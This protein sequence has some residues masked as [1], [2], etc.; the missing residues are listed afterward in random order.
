MPVPRPPTSN[1]PAAPKAR[2]GPTLEAVVL[3][4]GLSSRMGRDKSRLVLAGRTLAS[5]SAD[6]ARA[7]D[8]PVRTLR[9]DA[10]PRCGPLG[11]IA[12]ALS[13][14]RA[15]VLVFLSCDM[16][17]LGERVLRRLIAAM[18]PRRAAAFVECDGRIGFPFALRKDARPAV[19]ALR[20][21][22]SYSLRG[23]AEALGAA[24]VRIPTRWYP[25]LENVNTPEAFRALAVA[26][27]SKPGAGRSSPSSSRTWTSHA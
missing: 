7:L 24:K 23:L 18:T 15:D 16:P 26:E 10:V 21:R 12:T 25:D 2:T 6:A 27:D 22:G 19:E 3:A 1:D 20:L 17:R 11:G 4:G 5:R 9:R 14:P 13:R 8:I